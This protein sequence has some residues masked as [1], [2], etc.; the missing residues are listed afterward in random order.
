[1]DATNSC[2]GYFC[3]KVTEKEDVDVLHPCIYANAFSL[4][5]SIDAGLLMVGSVGSAHS[6]IQQPL[7]MECDWRDLYNYDFAFYC[8]GALIGIYMAIALIAFWASCLD[9]NEPEN[10]G[11]PGAQTKT[12]KKPLSKGDITRDAV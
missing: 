2:I 4:Y 3:E 6:W 1:M 8:A 11:K 12:G 7:C 5:L 10:K 9:S